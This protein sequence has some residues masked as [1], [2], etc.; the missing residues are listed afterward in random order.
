MI[1][2][3]SL[4][5]T[6]VFIY[7]FPL[8]VSL[9]R[10]HTHIGLPGGYFNFPTSNPCHFYIGVALWELNVIGLRTFRGGTPLYKSYGYVQPQNVWF[11]GRF[12]SEN[13]KNFAQFGLDCEQ[14][15]CTACTFTG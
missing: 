14:A 1:T 10:S 11:L 12:R 7:A 8:R 9:I 15:L 3:Y 5:T 13:G 2:L 4:K 6:N